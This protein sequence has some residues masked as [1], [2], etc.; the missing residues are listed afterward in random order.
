[1]HSLLNMPPVE[2]RHKVEQVKSFLD[3][4]PYSKNPLHDAVKE[5]KGARGKSCTGQA[6]QLIQHGV[7]SHRAEASKGLGK[8]RTLPGMTSCKIR[9]RNTDACRSL[10]QVT[11][12]CG[13]RGLLSH[14]A[15]VWLE[16]YCQAELKDCVWSRRC[17]QS[18]DLQFDHRGRS[19]YT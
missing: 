5:E 6:E 18:H 15:L 11:W 3:V 17:L 1:M 7:Q 9:C 12:H 16:V 2:T 4:M 14:K 8:T 13:L 10:Q 19:S